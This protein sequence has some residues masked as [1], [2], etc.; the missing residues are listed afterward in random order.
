MR[1]VGFTTAVGFF[2]PRVA[3]LEERAL[4][5]PGACESIRAKLLATLPL[6]VLVAVHP[7]FKLAGIGGGHVEDRNQADTIISFKLGRVTGL[8]RKMEDIT[9]FARGEMSTSPGKL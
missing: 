1:V 7:T 6:L 2:T 3:K 5:S 4:A 9:T 8:V